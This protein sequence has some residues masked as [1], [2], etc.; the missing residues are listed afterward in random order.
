MKRK[1]ESI[2][3][4][5]RLQPGDTV[6]IAAPAGPFRRDALKRGVGILR[7][8]G[9]RVHIPEG[10]NRQDGYLA[11]S[12]FHRAALLSGLFADPAIKA[13][14]CARGGYGSM[15]IL[16][17]LD[18]QKIRKTPKI[19]IGFSDVTAL[20]TALYMRCGLAT[21][22]GPLVT[23]LADSTRKSVTAMNRALSSG[24]SI[25]LATTKKHGVLNP[26]LAAG[27]VIGGNLTTLC[28]LLKTP[29][30]PC[31]E[32]HILFLED[33]GEA[34][35]RIDRMLG[36]MKLAGCFAGLRGLALGTFKNCGPV[37]TIRRIVRD[38]FR[39]FQIP[40]LWGLDI[41]HGRS[42]LTLPLGLSAVLDTA[43]GSLRFRQ[44]AT[45]G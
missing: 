14:W 8:L 29:F 41:G 12:D 10:L 16:P 17:H 36:Q 9:Y 38:M 40:I 21:F 3:I 7:E 34:A 37:R 5:E 23:T 44:P 6:G 26:G 4:A 11:G 18:Y 13:V 19:L 28:H 32:G 42:N 25:C 43:E 24:E 20:L 1:K 2:V 15:R 27:P 45:K 35:Y 33:T 30:E 22:H 39:D 31:F